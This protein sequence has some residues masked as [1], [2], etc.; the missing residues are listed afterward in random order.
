MGRLLWTRRGSED[1]ARWWPYCSLLV[2][3]TG[4][5]HQCDLVENVIL[6]SMIKSGF[7]LDVLSC[8]WLEF[9]LVSS[10]VTGSSSQLLTVCVG[11][12]C[13]RLDV[14]GEQG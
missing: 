1:T 5:G 13:R 11:V 9:R 4:R 3:K 12:C 2:S 10:P 7:Q 8:D 6:R 14:P